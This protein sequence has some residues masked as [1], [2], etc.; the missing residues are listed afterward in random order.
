M[1]GACWKRFKS[2]LFSVCF[3]FQADRCVLAKDISADL[4]PMTGQPLAHMRSFDKR[5]CQYLINQNI[6]GAVVTVAYKGKIIFSR[7]YGF[8]NEETKQQMQPGSLFR[9]ASLSKPLTA[10]GILSLCEKGKVKLSDKAFTILNDMKPCDPNDSIDPRIYSITIKDLLQCSAGW[11]HQGIDDPIF[12]NWLMKTAYSCTNNLRPTNVSIIRSVLSKRLDSDPGGTYCYS[13]V[14][15]CILGQIIEKL[16]GERYGEYIRGLILRPENLSSFKLGSTRKTEKNE[17]IYYAHESVLPCLLPN[18]RGQVSA[19]YGSFFLLEAAPASIGWIASTEDLVRFLSVLC[20]EDKNTN[21]PINKKS[22]EQ[23]LARPNL[24]YWKDSP[25]YFGFGFEVE[26]D[27]NGKLIAFSRHGS[28]PG[29]MALME[30]QT[31][32]ITWA[33]AFNSRPIPYEPNREIGKTI[34]KGAMKE[35]LLKLIR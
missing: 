11:D 35:L 17:V 33:A 15:Y 30:H 31:S 25:E 12:L 18:V 28:L 29:C 7:G 19:A 26:R 8:A 13:N 23:M 1:L 9:I 32:G 16:T 3:L 2:I 21:P 22:F 34:I 10:I 24:D 20:G 27:R 14:S 6:P 4:L 5:F